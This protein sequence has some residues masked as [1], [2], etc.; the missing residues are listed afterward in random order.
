M[1]LKDHEKINNR[2][3][4]D[5]IN[6]YFLVL[7]CGHFNYTSHEVRIFKLLTIIDR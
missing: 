5:T 2:L 1:D 3:Y 4:F 6:N 7:H